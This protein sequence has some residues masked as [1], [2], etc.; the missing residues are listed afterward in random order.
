MTDPICSLPFYHA[1]L[2][3]DG[4]LTFVETFEF[5][6]K[7]CYWSSLPEII[8]VFQV[9]VAVQNAVRKRKLQKIFSFTSIQPLR[10]CSKS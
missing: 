8:D 2:F 1:I 3:Q 6:L 5:V 9:L 10:Y 7:T 4:Q